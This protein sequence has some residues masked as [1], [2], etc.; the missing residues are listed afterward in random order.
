MVS[1]FCQYCKLL[2]AVVHHTHRVL[3]DLQNRANEGTRETF[4]IPRAGNPHRGDSGGGYC[5][6]R[7]CLVTVLCYA[8]GNDLLQDV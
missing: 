2:L 8:T 5:G 1:A 7:R 6:I 4:A 3:F